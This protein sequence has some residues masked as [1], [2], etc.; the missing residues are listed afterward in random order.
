LLKLR[1]NLPKSATPNFGAHELVH[2]QR[3]VYDGAPDRSKRKATAD[4]RNTQHTVPRK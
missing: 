2:E 4:C 3:F 1:R